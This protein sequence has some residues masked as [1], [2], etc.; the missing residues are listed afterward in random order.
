M[1]RTTSRQ[2]PPPAI[3]GDVSR[4]YRYS[5][6]SF[7]N[8]DF[9]VL[10]GIAPA[11]GMSATASDMARFMLAHLNGGEVDGVGLLRPETTALMHGRQF[12]HDA[13]IPGMT[14]GLIERAH[15][16]LR[17]IGHGGNLQWFHSDLALVPSERLGIFVSYNT[18]TGM[19]LSRGRLVRQFLDHY[20]ELEPETSVISQPAGTAA[21]LSGYFRPTRMSYTTF[22]KATMLT[23]T[24]SIS[25]SDDGGL[26]LS[27]M[28]G[29]MRLQPVSPTIYRDE[30][31]GDWVVFKTDSDGRA[32]HAFVASLPVAAFERTPWYQAPPIHWVVLSLS[33][34]VFVITSF[35]AA[36]RAWRWL[37]TGDLEGLRRIRPLLV[38]IASV[39]VLFVVAIASLLSTPIVMT[40]NGALVVDALLM[41]PSVAALLTLIAAIGLLKDWTGRRASFPA[42]SIA[43]VC[44]AVGWTWSLSQWNLLWP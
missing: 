4:G 43:F 39:N 31:T 12:A 42:L 14:L 26:L 34:V 21:R 28:I 23:D 11:G 17:V 3:A 2:P 15:G 41:L 24:M 40:S 19:Q 8:Q 10:T 33:I 27:S 44:V 38:V 37:I 30:L 18:D 32:T 25:A 20:F 22:Q 35:N 9:E 29:T 13:S 7:V 5:N 16:A 36:Y 6:G 1:T